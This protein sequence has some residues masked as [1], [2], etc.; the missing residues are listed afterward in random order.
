MVERLRCHVTVAA[1]IER[2]G[3]YLFVEERVAGQRVLNQPAGHL[4]AGEDLHQAVIREVREETGLEFS[5]EAWLGCELLT[6]SD[7]A[8]ILRVAFTGRAAGGAPAAERDPAILATHWL[9]VEEATDWGPLR[10]P[11][12]LRSLERHQA[13]LR[14]PL[15]ALGFLVPAVA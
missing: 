4:E 10:S 12:V 2:D 13:G 1:V 7:G 3:R 9:T 5:P 8:V 11:L 15:N 6:L 14:L